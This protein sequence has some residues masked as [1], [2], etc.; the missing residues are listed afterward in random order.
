VFYMV[1]PGVNKFLT[2]LS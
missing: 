1:R 2:E